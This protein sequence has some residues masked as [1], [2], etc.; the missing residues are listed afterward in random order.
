M[1]NLKKIILIIPFFILSCASAQ[2]LESYEPINA[3][4]ET[5]KI[6]KNKKYILQAD[7]AE[8]INALQI[9]NGGEGEKYIIDSTRPSDN[10]DGLFAENIGKKY[11]ANTH[12]IPLRGIGKKRIFLLIISF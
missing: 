8:N 3:F 9:F 11:I 6:D 10:T 5:Q 4:F 7:K 12:M 1:K 2:Y